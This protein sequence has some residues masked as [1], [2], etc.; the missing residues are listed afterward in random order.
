MAIGKGLAFRNNAGQPLSM[1]LSVYLKHIVPLLIYL[2]QWD[3]HML[4][5]KRGHREG[6]EQM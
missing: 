1:L 4:L 5:Q 6:R 2:E 3:G